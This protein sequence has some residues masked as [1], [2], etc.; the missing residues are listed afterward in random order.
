MVKA[1][2]LQGYFMTLF[3]DTQVI[4]DDERKILQ[5]LR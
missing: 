3:R 4:S 2:M 5:I 1:S